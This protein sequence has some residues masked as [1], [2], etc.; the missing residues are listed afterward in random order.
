MNSRGKHTLTNGIPGLVG[1][2]I[3]AVDA[4]SNHEYRDEKAVVGG[5]ASDDESRLESLQQVERSKSHGRHESRA[6]ESIGDEVGEGRGLMGDTVQISGAATLV[7][8]V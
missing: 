5:I 1:V 6:M 7:V 3:I 8:E 2:S 4:G